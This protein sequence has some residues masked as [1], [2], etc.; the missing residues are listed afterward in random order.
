MEVY[1]ILM[2]SDMFYQVLFTPAASGF[3]KE[4]L[5]S[6]SKCKY[7]MKIFLQ[8]IQ[9]TDLIKWIFQL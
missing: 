2:K 6:E 4:I 3:P 9:R 5:H 1:N 7:N 8:R